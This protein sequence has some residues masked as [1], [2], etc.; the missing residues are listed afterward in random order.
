MLH[1]Y[2]GSPDM[3]AAFAKLPRGLG[4][5]FYFGFSH[6]INGTKGRQK[7]LE[8]IRWGARL[9]L[10]G[11]GGGSAGCAG[12]LVRVVLLARGSAAGGG[13]GG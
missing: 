13:G 2:G 9:L 5:R 11:A 3:V 4:R 10:R 7:L 6:V 1:S 12:V 8:R